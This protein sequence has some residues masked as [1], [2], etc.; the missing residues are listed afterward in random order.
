MAT[1]TGD[2]LT[3]RVPFF[4]LQNTELDGTRQALDEGL[5]PM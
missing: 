4:N 5:T 1:P 2:S 3:L